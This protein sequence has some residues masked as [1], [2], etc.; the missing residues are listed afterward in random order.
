MKSDF[1]DD[2]IRVARCRRV[3]Q[4]ESGSFGR[5][6]H[7]HLDLE[8]LYNQYSFHSIFYGHSNNKVLNHD[9]INLFIESEF[10]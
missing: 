4:C 3:G 6:R 1:L 10:F 5:I 8:S 9:Y 7:Y 2:C